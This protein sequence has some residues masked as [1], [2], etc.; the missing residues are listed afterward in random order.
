M[1]I[2]NIIG[3]L[4]ISVVNSPSTVNPNKPYNGYNQTNAEE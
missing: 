2:W 4:G 3:S 1:V